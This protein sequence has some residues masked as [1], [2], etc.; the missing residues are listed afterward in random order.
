MRFFLSLLALGGVSASCMFAQNQMAAQAPSEKALVECGIDVR[1]QDVPNGDYGGFYSWP[2][3]VTEM[4]G[5]AK[6]TDIVRVQ[7]LGKSGEGRPIPLFHITG[8]AQTVAP[9]P[10]VFFVVGIHPREQAPTICIVRFINE[11]LAGYGKDPEITKLL[12]TRTLWVVPML[13][14]DGKIYD[15]QHGNGT[16]KGAD[17]RKNRRENGD[18]TYGVDLNR[19]F[20]IRWGGNRAYDAAWKTTTADTRGNIYEGPAPA[21]EP[22]TRAVMDFI[23]K[24]PLRVFLDL[25][26]PLHDMRSPGNLS[27]SE[28]DIFAGLLDKMQKTQK[29]PYPLQVPKAAQEPRTETRG[30][31][32]G[33]S[34]PWAYYS[35]G[36]YSFNIEIGL[37][38]RYPVPATVE[39]EYTDNIRGPL[40]TLL[41]EATD[42]K[43]AG[44]GDLKFGASQ[45]DGKPEPGERIVWKPQIKGDY[46]YAIAQSADAA[47]VIPMEFHLAPTTAGFPIL[48]QKEA[49]PG[50]R[51]PLS[52]YVWDD[53]RQL[54]VFKDTLV[55]R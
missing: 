53:K 26:S 24:H 8:K 4:K 37:K 27:Q 50:T 55:V 28:R 52:L 6:H 33:I 20:P 41:R 29:E 31:D 44:K 32:S 16:T 12:D 45:W 22:E 18:G 34:Y 49:K 11:L 7:S 30:G 23:S 19:N 2:E 39:Q 51:I 25:H 21:S 5:W 3:L 48:I 13:N 1:P 14:V 46:S 10:E 40:F 38:G 47:G 36:A 42:L 17:W 35:T 15:F 54:T 9:K 43:A